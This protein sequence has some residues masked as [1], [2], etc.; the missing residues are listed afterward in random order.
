[1]PGERDRGSEHFD[2]AGQSPALSSMV[3][4]P[5]T[6]ADLQAIEGTFCDSRSREEGAQ[7]I[8]VTGGFRGYP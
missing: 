5:G 2:Q 7:G 3:Y 8:T 4:S 6:S 1:M